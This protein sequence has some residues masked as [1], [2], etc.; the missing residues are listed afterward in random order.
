MLYILEVPQSPVFTQETQKYDRF[1][2]TIMFSLNRKKQHPSLDFGEAYVEKG[3]EDRPTTYEMPD[4][5]TGTYFHD[6]MWTSQ[7]YLRC[8]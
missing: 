3:E 5:I 8:S 7:S 4:S 6:F 2:C 1:R